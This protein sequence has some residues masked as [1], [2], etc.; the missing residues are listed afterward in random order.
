MRNSPPLPWVTDSNVTFFSQWRGFFLCQSEFPVRPSVL[1]ACCSVCPCEERTP[2][3][4]IPKLWGIV[5]LWFSLSLLFYRLEQIQTLQCFLVCQGIQQHNYLGSLPVDPFHFIS[6]SFEGQGTK[7]G[8][9]I[10][11]SLRSSE[12]IG[13]IISLDLL[14][15]LLLSWSL[16]YG[17]PS[18]LQGHSADSH[19]AC[20]PLGLPGPFQQGYTAVRP[21]PVLLLGIVLFQVQHFTFSFVKPH[22]V[23]ADLVFH[24]ICMVALPSSISTSPHSSV[25][26]ANLVR[27]HSILLNTSSVKILNPVS[28]CEELHS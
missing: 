15:K 25:S 12:Y 2:I 20:C 11:R 22:T 9:N 3:F 27:V 21:Q 19:S 6:F 13:M 1:I 4:S 10:R 7:T 8:H 28:P 5:W 17:L 14:A 24:P 16:G 26:S 23:P 18:L